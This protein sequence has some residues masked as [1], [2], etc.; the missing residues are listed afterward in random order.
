MFHSAS[1][2]LF[3]LDLEGTWWRAL[4]QLIARGT[5]APVFATFQFLPNG[6]APESSARELHRCGQKGRWM[7]NTQTNPLRATPLLQ[8]SPCR[9]REEKKWDY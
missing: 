5:F 7:A 4:M 3:V 1:I 6:P 2:F 8:E 9:K